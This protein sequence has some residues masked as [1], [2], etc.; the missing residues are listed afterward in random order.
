M[1]AA[2]MMAVV[3]ALAFTGDFLLA[4]IGATVDKYRNTTMILGL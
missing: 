4:G 2:V 1:M 3:G